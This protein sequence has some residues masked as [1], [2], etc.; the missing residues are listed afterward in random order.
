MEMLKLL[1][2]E[3]S[4]EFCGALVDRLRGAYHIRTC[5]EG[6]ETLEQIISYR[7]DILVLDMMLPGLDGI[8]LLQAAAAAGQRPMVLAVSK[9]ISDYMLESL[10]QLGVGYIM[11]KPCDVKA[12]ASRISDLTQQMK[13]PLF[14][15]PDPRTAA[16]NLLLTLSV[17]T[18]LK[19]YSNLRDAI[20]MVMKD[21]S[22]SLT[23]ELYPAVGKLCN[24]SSQQVERAIRSAIQAAW[25]QRDEQVWRMYFQPEKNGR[26]PKPTNGAFISRL[27]DCLMNGMEEQRSIE[28]PKEA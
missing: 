5:A 11:R 4:E 12:T 17:P 28:L 27:A 19:G 23:K 10:S 15:H 18:K 8:S 16:S 2:A 14:A 25:L 26:I 9:F 3:G 24:S 21:P 13:M 7:P 20:P 1:I 22:I 6:C